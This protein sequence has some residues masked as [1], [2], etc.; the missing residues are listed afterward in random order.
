MTS[1]PKI[2]TCKSRA[3]VRLAAGDSQ[4][5]YWNDDV[6]CKECRTPLVPADKV[7]HNLDLI[8]YISGRR[9]H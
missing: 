3:V 6:F 7:I 2:A 9:E 8:Q 4:A 1:L 5:V